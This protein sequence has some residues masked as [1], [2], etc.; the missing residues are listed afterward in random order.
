VY[1]ASATGQSRPSTTREKTHANYTRRNQSVCSAVA[2]S[3]A[4]GWAG[5]NQRPASS[6]AASHGEAFHLQ[7]AS[8]AETPSV[9]AELTPLGRSLAHR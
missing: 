7:P 5:A 3:H 2:G 1:T 8:V 6:E 4:T 9:A